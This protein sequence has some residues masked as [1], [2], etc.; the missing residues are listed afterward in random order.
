[1]TGSANADCIEQLGQD[2]LGDYLGALSPA[3][4]R[5]VDEALAVALAL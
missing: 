5:S 3:T 4:M 1:V 2:E